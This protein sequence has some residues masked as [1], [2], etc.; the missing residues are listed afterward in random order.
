M[1]KAPSRIETKECTLNQILLP[2]SM[3]E[4]GSK[5]ANMIAVVASVLQ[6][7]LINGQ[8]PPSRGAEGFSLQNYS[9]EINFIN[10]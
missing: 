5:R 4:V 2:R 8:E 7:T 10:N 3:P 6:K 9:H 1:H